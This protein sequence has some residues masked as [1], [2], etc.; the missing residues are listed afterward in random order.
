MAA[1]FTACRATFTAMVPGIVRDIS[2]VLR[3]PRLLRL[4][5]DAA[6]C[7]ASL[8]IDEPLLDAILNTSAVWSLLKFMLNYDYTLEECEVERSEEQNE[9]VRTIYS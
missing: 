9:Q 5:C 3:L 8:A 1:Q 6:Q 7:L 4:A 2:S